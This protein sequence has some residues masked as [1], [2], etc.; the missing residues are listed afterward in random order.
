[1]PVVSSALLDEVEHDPP[2]RGSDP[3]CERNRGPVVQVVLSMISALGL[4]GR[5]SKDLRERSRCAVDELL[6]R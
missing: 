4:D 5:V 6:V 3:R 1:M 2:Q